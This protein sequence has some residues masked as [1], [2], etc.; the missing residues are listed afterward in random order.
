MERAKKEELEK[1]HQRSLSRRSF[2]SAAAISSDET[3]DMLRDIGQCRVTQGARGEA[4]AL[5]Y[6]PRRGQEVRTG[7]REL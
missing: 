6:Q 2:K 5:K 7:K 1:E 3:H 4:H